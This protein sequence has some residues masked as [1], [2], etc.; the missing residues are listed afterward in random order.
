M[1]DLIMFLPAVRLSI[2]ILFPD[3]RSKYEP[4]YVKDE[5]NSKAFERNI[6]P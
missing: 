6:F 4:F 3:S 1:L 2:L 5:F